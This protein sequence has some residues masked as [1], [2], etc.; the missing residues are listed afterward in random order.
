VASGYQLTLHYSL[1]HCAPQGFSLPK[2]PDM[3]DATCQLQKVLRN[4]R[5]GLY[6]K[7][8]PSFIAYVLDNRYTTQELQGGM[9]SLKKSD[10]HKLTFVLPTAKELGYVVAL[11]SLLHVITGYAS[12][13]RSY[14]QDAESGEDDASDIE[15][16][17]DPE[18]S[19]TISDIVDL[20]GVAIPG[21]TKF[22]IGTESFLSGTSINKREPD[23]KEYEEFPGYVRAFCCFVVLLLTVGFVPQ[24]SESR[25]VDYRELSIKKKNLI[26]V[27]KIL[28][29]RFLSNG[30][31]LSS[32]K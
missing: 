14:Q 6:K 10:L 13:Y 9:I 3:A 29:Y 28:S 5:D 4:W 26:Q 20:D 21:L 7:P 17:E 11:G 18:T 8:I 2:L 30:N 24:T 1:V 16:M 23:E 12:M 31:D 15:R 32:R 19:T 22:D 27:L 25:Q